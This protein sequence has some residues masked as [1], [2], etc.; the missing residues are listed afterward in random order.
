MY[1]AGTL[2]IREHDNVIGVVRAN[3]LTQTF[4]DASQG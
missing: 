1:D 4:L 2:V 3:N